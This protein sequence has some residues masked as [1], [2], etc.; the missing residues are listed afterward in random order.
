MPLNASPPTL[1]GA[2]FDLKLASRR[3][4]RRTSTSRSGAASSRATS[5]GS[6]SSRTGRDRL[7]GIHVPVRDR[8]LP[9]ADDETLRD[10]MARAARA[11]AAGRGACRERGA[12]GTA[13][14]RGSRRGPHVAARLP[15][16]PAGRRRARGGRPRDRDRAETGARFTSSTSRAA[17]GAARRGGPRPRRRRHLRDLP[18]L[19]RARRGRRGGDR[20]GREVLAADPA[21]SGRRGPLADRPRRARRPRRVGPLAEPAGAEAGRG[22]VRRL[23]RDRRRADAAPVLLTEGL[24]RGLR[25]RRSRRSTAAAPARRSACGEGIDRTR[26]R[27]RSR[28]RRPRPEDVL[29]S[30]ELLSRHRLSPFLWRTLRGRIARTIVRGC[31]VA[32][33]GVIVAPPAGRLVRPARTSTEARS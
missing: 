3:R 16:L 33:D 26:R 27:R 8:R 17:S 7:Q 18:A 4:G 12:D 10:G 11:R 1:D 9:A 14:R 21:A 31:T 20:D 28:P 13:R 32:L 6:T 22:R 25:S 29:R 30:G 19:P 2:S 23:G 15:A 24:P 5:T